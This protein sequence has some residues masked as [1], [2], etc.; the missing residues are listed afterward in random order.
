MDDIVKRC[1]FSKDLRLKLSHSL[2]LKGE[3]GLEEEGAKL[4]ESIKRFGSIYLAAKH[5]GKDYRLAW[6]S[7]RELEGNF[8]FKVVD[9]VMGGM[10][11]GSTRLTLEGEILLERFLLA[12]RKFGFLAGS[13]KF[14]EPD[15]KIMGSHCYA[16]DILVRLIE[17]KFGGFF[18]E[19]LNVGSEWGLKLVLSGVADISGIHIFKGDRGGYNAFLF[20]EKAVGRKIALIRGYSRMQGIIVGEGNPKRI[21]SLNDLL[22]E[23]IVFI[24]RNKGSGTRL[25]FDE[26]IRKLSL[27]RGEKLEK[28]V[29]NIRGYGSEV[30]SHLEV[31]CAVKYGKADAGIGIKAV[32]KSYKLGFVPLL[33]ENFD[34]AVLRKNVE[35]DNVRKFIEVLSSKRFQSTISEKDLGIFFHEDTGKVLIN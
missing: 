5:E 30:R 17:E 33:R 25:L 23:D 3:D 21:K 22:R 8:G 11:G 14:L 27:E 19:L 4:L 34:F 16:L 32:A 24:N 18:V 7:L 9:R 1:G 13:P 31:A 20:K 6:L 26:A 28:L 15:L 10:G 2:V 35:S 29:K 12:K